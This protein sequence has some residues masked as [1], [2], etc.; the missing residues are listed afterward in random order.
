M[1]AIAHTGELKMIYKDWQIKTIVFSIDYVTKPKIHN[2][3][4]QRLP[5]TRIVHKGIFVDDSNHHS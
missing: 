4:K 5:G 2:K 1:M 3:N